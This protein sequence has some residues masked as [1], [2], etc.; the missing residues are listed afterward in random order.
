MISQRRI[1]IAALVILANAAVAL[2]FLPSAQACVDECEKPKYL[3]KAL[4]VCLQMSL[5]EKYAYC[6]RSPFAIVFHQVCL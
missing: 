6:Q 2:Q 5:A 1:R 3:C 4:D